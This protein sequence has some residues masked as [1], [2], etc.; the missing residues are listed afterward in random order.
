MV[1]MNG[2]GDTYNVT[3]TSP[4]VGLNVDTTISN[5]TLSG[6]SGRITA[7]DR[8]LTVEGGTSLLPAGRLTLNAVSSAEV[9]FDLGALA[10]FSGTGIFANAGVT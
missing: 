4:F 5:L 2:G 7:T 9:K 1:P 6:T 10:N 8:N 3:I